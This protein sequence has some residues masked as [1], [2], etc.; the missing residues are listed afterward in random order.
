MCGIVQEQDLIIICYNAGTGP[1]Q[2]LQNPRKSIPELPP[3]P[4]GPLPQRC[5]ISQQ[6][7]CC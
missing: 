5:S 7:P 2:D 6:R 4:G 1:D 3:D